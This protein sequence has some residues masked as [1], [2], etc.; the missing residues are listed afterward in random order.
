MTDKKVLGRTMVD[1]NNVDGQPDK[2]NFYPTPLPFLN[3][4][5]WRLQTNKDYRCTH[6]C[7]GLCRTLDLGVGTG[8]WAVPISKIKQKR[9]IHGIEYNMGR[10]MQMPNYHDLYDKIYK[11]NIMD[12]RLKPYDQYTFVM[13][14]PPYQ[15]KRN[16]NPSTAEIVQYAFRHLLADKGTMVLLLDSRFSHGIDRYRKFFSQEKQSPY[17]VIN[18]ANRI[19][20]Y[21]ETGK[22]GSYPTEYSVFLW[23]KGERHNHYK[24][25]TEYWSDTSVKKID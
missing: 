2:D 6:L 15:R 21:T 4:L 3:W 11:Q 23:R 19:N 5:F 18:L 17:A 20:F 14:N 12:V 24:A 22:G 25:Y 16:G 9:Y 13:G 1:L 10:Y 8:H 7:T